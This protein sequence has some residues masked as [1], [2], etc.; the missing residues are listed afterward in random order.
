MISETILSPNTRH[1]M[2]DASLDRYIATGATLKMGISDSELRK[3]G[4]DYNINNE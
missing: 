1:Y 2:F 3:V 4:I